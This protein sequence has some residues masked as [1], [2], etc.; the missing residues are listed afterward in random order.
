MRAMIADLIAN[1][2]RAEVALLVVWAAALADFLRNEAVLGAVCAA[3]GFAWQVYRRVKSKSE[4]EKLS[5]EVQVMLR[6]AYL[7]GQRT[8]LEKQGIVK[9]ETGQYQRVIGAITGELEV[10]NE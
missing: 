6:A 2:N 1:H 7:E 3:I 4:N 10:S 8:A 5:R 9:P